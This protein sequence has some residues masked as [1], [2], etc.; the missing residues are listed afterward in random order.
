MECHLSMPAC[1]Q[2]THDVVSYPSLIH[3]SSSPKGYKKE[4]QAGWWRPTCLWFCGASEQFQNDLHNA[5]FVF[6]RDDDWWVA[7]TLPALVYTTATAESQELEQIWFDQTTTPS[8]TR[9]PPPLTP[10]KSFFRLCL[11][12]PFPPFDLPLSLNMAQTPSTQGV[13]LGIESMFAQIMEV[14][15]KSVCRAYFVSAGHW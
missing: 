2:N 5:R 13:P 3:H 10:T 15:R 14:V 11:S 12:F 7:E 8:T 9:R 1:L 4:G 6:D